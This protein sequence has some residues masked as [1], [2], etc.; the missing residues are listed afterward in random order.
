MNTK[1]NQ[2]AKATQA[3][4]TAAFLRLLETREISKISIQELCRMADVNRSTFYAHYQDI[5]DLFTRME[6]QMSAH[7]VDIFYDGANNAYR[8]FNQQRYTELFSYILQNRQFYQTYLKGGRGHTINLHIT[9]YGRKML[10]P[11]WQ[12]LSESQRR[13]LEYRIE[14][15]NAGINAII[16]HWLHSGCRETP[17]ELAAILAQEDNLRLPFWEQDAGV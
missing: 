7:M 17:Q 12:Q 8:P 16:R 5:Y 13:A 10:E 4:I 6:E 9:E 3:R 15:F 11:V 1:G 14:Y 2:R